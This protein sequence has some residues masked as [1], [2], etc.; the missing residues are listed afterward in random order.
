MITVI[1]HTPLHRNTPIALGLP[2]DSDIVLPLSITASYSFYVQT[3]ASNFLLSFFSCAAVFFSLAVRGVRT[4]ARLASTPWLCVL[5]SS[6][7]FF[8]L[9]ILVL[10]F[11]GDWVL[12]GSV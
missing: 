10:T 8:K 4:W 11:G 2:M 5:M 1:Y 3:S 6:R 9:E 12:V 7:T